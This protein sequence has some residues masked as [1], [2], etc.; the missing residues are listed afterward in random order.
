VNVSALRRHRFTVDEYTRLAPVLAGQ[1]TELVDGW[2]IDLA[3][4]GTAHL[5]VVSRLQDVL[6]PQLLAGQV[7]IQ[8][9]LIVSGFD[10]PEPDVVVLNEPLYLRKPTIA[11]TLL[12]IEVSDS[13][14]AHDH[15]YKLPAYFAAGCRRVWIINLSIHA[16][17]ALEMYSS[18]DRVAERRHHGHVSLPGGTGGLEIAEVNL[19]ELFAGVP[20]LP[21]D[22]FAEQP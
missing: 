7:K 21:P 17:P 4:I 14:Y 1:R 6:V 18:P 13:T 9:P 12:V 10:E 20:G 8:Q 3:P 2:V 15:D 16:S 5:T 19:D 11:D 22:E